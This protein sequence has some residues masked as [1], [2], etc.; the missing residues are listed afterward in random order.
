MQSHAHIGVSPVGVRSRGDDWI[1]PIIDFW[2][3]LRVQD[4]TGATTWDV[5]E[6][7]ERRVTKALEA[8]PPDR[9]EAESATAEAF[10]LI[11]GFINFQ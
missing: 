8:S 5:L 10:G 11:S 3:A 9:F 4:Q 6:V 7:L 2:N 1:E